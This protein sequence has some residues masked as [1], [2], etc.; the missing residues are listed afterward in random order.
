MGIEE[1]FASDAE[2][3]A[4]SQPEA[5]KETP[6]F[7][8]DEY[9]YSDLKQAASDMQAEKNAD[10]V[11]PAG[12][13]NSAAKD[14]SVEAAAEPEPASPVFDE[15]LLQRAD[16]FGVPRE[17]AMEFS[18][19]KELA[20]ALWVAENAARAVAA[21]MQ[22]EAQTVTSQE[23]DELAAAIEAIKQDPDGYDDN[24][25][26]ALTGMEDRLRRY[27]QALAFQLNASQRQI[28][29]ERDA[30]FNSRM[31]NLF[32]SVEQD[33][34]FGKGN[35]GDVAPKAGQ[36]PSGHFSNRDRV[37]QQFLVQ[38]DL[39]MRRGE[40]VSD[41]VLMNRAMAAEFGDRMQQQIQRGLAQKVAQRSSQILP[42]AG[43]N[44]SAAPA[45]DYDKFSQIY[46]RV[47]GGSQGKTQ[48]TDD[49]F[50]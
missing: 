6:A 41:S 10:Y 21:P 44:K 42:R 30:V 22:Q 47:M 20:R 16:A 1:V 26:S 18:N 17:V 15:L 27:E 33:D 8:Q 11:E 24:I 9:D 43:S 34:L 3:A 46:D 50:A 2:N 29:N 32:N 28:E 39:A 37:A 7:L 31:D 45:S 4:A 48:T 40:R 19:P 25:K 35:Y 5:A 14:T 23:R 38:E 49:I 13:A 12:D 36:A